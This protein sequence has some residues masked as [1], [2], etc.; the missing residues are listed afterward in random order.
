MPHV[1][2]TWQDDGLVDSLSLSLATKR[3]R[4]LEFR[5]ALT[6]LEG[7]VPTYTTRPKLELIVMTHF[8][9]QGST[10]LQALEFIKAMHRSTLKDLALVPLYCRRAVA[11]RVTKYS[12]T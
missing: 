12:S 7:G 5:V 4:V 2:L 9:F 11:T 3:A 10:R 1:S 6:C 8:F